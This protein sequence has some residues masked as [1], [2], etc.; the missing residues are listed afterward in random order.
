MPLGD[1]EKLRRAG[2][3]PLV[4]L[5]GIGLNFQDHYLTFSVY[6]AKPNVE[7]FD[8]FVRGA[9][10]E[11]VFNQ[12]NINGTGSLATNGI[13]AGVKVR[14]TEEELKEMDKWPTP[15]SRSGWESYFKNRPVYQLQ[16]I[17]MTC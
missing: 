15:E 11:K 16:I 14:P 10:Q 7:S 3:K 17:E 8:D 4:N 12:W 2:I 1:P 6:R 9:T 13:E 5:P